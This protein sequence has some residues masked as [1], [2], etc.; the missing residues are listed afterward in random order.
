MKYAYK[1]FHSDM[2][3]EAFFDEINNNIYL[4]V[5]KWYQED[6]LKLYGCFNDE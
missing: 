1:Q 2:E 5:D 6:G 3:I 4:S